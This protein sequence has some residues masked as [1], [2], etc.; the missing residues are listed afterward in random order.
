[1]KPEKR[2]KRTK[3]KPLPF[4]IA[5]QNARVVHRPF[6]VSWGITTTDCMNNMFEM[7]AP[8]SAT[9]A[10]RIQQDMRD[11]L[12]AFFRPA[13]HSGNEP[14]RPF[15]QRGLQPGRP[16]QPPGEVPGARPH[17]RLSQF[18]QSSEVLATVPHDGHGCGEVN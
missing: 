14:R 13:N 5:L 15:N 17:A 9:E 7:S 6:V 8:K 16:P 1:M 11:R 2:M 4:P 18:R 3:I 12:Y 10:L